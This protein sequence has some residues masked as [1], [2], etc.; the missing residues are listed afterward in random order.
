MHV[1]DAKLGM[2]RYFMNNFINKFIIEIILVLGR[3]KLETLDSPRDM[4]PESFSSLTIFFVSI[5]R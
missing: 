2:Q 4:A 5:P 3:L 1:N